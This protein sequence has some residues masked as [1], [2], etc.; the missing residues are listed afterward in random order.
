MIQIS[1]EI[2]RSAQINQRLTEMRERHGYPQN[3]KN[4]L[5]M[6]YFDII[7]EHHQAIGLLIKENLIGSSFAFVR[8]IAETLYRA[9]WVNACATKQQLE[10][11]FVDDDFDF[12]KDMMEKI[13]T[14]YSTQDFFQNLKRLT[15]KSMCSYTHSGSLQIA[16][17]FGGNDGYVGPNYS[18]AEI[19]EVLRATTAMLILIAILFFKG[20]GCAKEALEVERIGLN[21]ESD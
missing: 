5:L 19:L 7:A 15:W 6:A 12:P 20:T 10:Q 21:A 9:A 13:D 2:S 18:E 17:R 11:I 8:P 4:D 14:A 3:H 1:E 16:R